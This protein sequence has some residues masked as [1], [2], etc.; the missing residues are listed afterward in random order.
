M[1]LDAKV[2]ESYP[3][4]DA[5]AVDALLNAEIAENLRKTRR[6]VENLIYRAKQ[7]LRAELEKEGIAD[8]IV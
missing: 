2:L 5:A 6:Q 1:K 7:A 4:V 3:A 8:E